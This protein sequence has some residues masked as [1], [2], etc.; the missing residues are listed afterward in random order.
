MKEATGTRFVLREL[1]LLCGEVVFF[2]L[3][4]TSGPGAGIPPAPGNRHLPSFHT[5]LHIPPASGL[6]SVYAFPLLR[7][8]SPSGW[9]SSALPT[10]L[11]RQC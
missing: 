11:S 3:A 8:A 6:V 5:C 4:S 9:P 10:D 1:P 7:P 2:F